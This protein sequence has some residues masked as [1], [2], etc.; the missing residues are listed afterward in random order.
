MALAP[1]FSLLALPSMASISESIRRCSLA[2][3][4]KPTSLGPISSMTASTAFS[5]PLPR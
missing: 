5:T 2:S 1:S 3:M 4:P